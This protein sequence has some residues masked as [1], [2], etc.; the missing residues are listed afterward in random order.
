VT[1]GVSDREGH[2]KVAL[3]THRGQEEGA[4]VDGGVE[5]ETSD[6]T[7]EE[8]EVPVHVI[9][10][11]LHLEG[12]ESEEDEVGDGQVEEQDVDG[13]RFAAHLLAKGAECQ[14]VG[15]YPNQEGGNVNRQ[16]QMSD[17]HGD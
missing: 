15:R 13:G 6:W 14:D 5:Q 1:Q 2:T 7:Q 12:Q 11:L 16:Q 4:V 8:G 17:R 3:H 10:S 9:N